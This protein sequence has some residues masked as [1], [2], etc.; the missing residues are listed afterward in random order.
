MS[1][2]KKPKLD[3][4]TAR[5][6]STLRKIRGMEDAVVDVVEIPIPPRPDY[7]FPYR[8]SSDVPSSGPHFKPEMVQEF[9]RMLTE[10]MNWKEE[11][12]E[13]DQIQDVQLEEEEAMQSEPKSESRKPVQDST[14]RNLRSSKIQKSTSTSKRKVTKQA[15]MGGKGN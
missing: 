7:M 14:T 13:Q 12:P 1:G 11:T 4:M 9:T 3:L 2:S 8:R 15:K 10:E 6:I 5:G